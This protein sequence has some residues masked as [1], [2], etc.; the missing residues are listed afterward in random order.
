M[1]GL[2]VLTDDFGSRWVYK[3]RIHYAERLRTMYRQR[4]TNIRL[5]ALRE[6]P[7]VTADGDRLTGCGPRR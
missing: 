6:I 7:T 2:P 1:D 5:D 4:P 3:M